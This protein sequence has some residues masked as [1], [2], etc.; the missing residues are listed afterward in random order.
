MQP[1]LLAAAA[2]ET[3][4][5]VTGEPGSVFTEAAAAV[6]MVAEL[7][8]MPGVEPP[9]VDPGCE[10][11]G[12]GT[13]VPMVEPVAPPAPAAAGNGPPPAAVNE[14]ADVDEGESAVA[15]DPDEASAAT[16]EAFPAPA[17][18]DE[19]ELALAEDGV[20]ATDRLEAPD[21]ELETG[22][23]DGAEEAPTLAEDD[24]VLAG[25]NETLLEAWGFRLL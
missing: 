10:L 7:D 22:A 17:A 20:I 1:A 23:E 4:E 14:G 2:E 11:T 9:T 8:I 19:G 3:M 21:V 15:V 6:A 16:D 18:A 24:E 5:A 12:D 25:A 13:G